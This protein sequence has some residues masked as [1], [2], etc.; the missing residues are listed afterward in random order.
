M[1]LSTVGSTIGTA[2]SF[3]SFHVHAA[4]HTGVGMYGMSR[5]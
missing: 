5:D 4:W 2:T 3:F 1:L